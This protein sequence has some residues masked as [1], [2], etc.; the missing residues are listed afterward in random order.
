MSNLH[1]HSDRS[2][3]TLE[4]KLLESEARLP[5]VAHPGEDL[6]YDIY[7]LNGTYV[8]TGQ[9]ERLRTGIA[10]SAKRNDYRATFRSNTILGE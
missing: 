3:Y 9:V 7:L 8:W 10:V 5:T 4:V 1:Y 6:G 2:H